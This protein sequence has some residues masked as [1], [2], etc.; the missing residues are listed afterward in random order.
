MVLD[1]CLFH[2][3]EVDTVSICAALDSTNVH[4]RI[5]APIFESE[6]YNVG[7]FK[8]VIVPVCGFA[9]NS[10]I[11][12]VLPFMCAHRSYSLTILFISLRSKFPA[13]VGM[14]SETSHHF[15]VVARAFLSFICSIVPHQRIFSRLGGEFVAFVPGVA[16]LFFELLSKCFFCF[17]VRVIWAHHLRHP[18]EAN[19][20]PSCPNVIF[21]VLPL[22]QLDDVK[23]GL[24][25]KSACRLKSC[26]VES[27][28]V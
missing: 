17:P 6:V 21:L 2:L 26:S 18:R 7:G 28:G 22:E 10:I 13:L 3:V 20:T 8:I 19:P 27:R 11:D 5:A 14:I 9:V 12:V 4:S 16:G 15:I 1:V 23:L 24:A 25:L